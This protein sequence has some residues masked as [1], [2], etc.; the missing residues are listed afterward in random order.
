MRSTALVWHKMTV[1]SSMVDS[2][3][4]RII[5]YT[6][7]NYKMRLN[8][9]LKRTT[10]NTAEVREFCLWEQ[11]KW[12]DS[13]WSNSYHQANVAH[14][15]FFALACMY[16]Q[17]YLTLRNHWSLTVWTKPKSKLNPS[18]NSIF[19]TWIFFDFVDNEIYY[20]YLYNSI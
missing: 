16:S 9:L 11:Q 15:S 6:L 14:L 13:R 12:T 10:D 3:T 1:L 19:K 18:I 20:L 2:S 5:Y 4:S 7:D 17:L 8:N